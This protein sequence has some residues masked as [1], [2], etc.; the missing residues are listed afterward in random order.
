MSSREPL[1]FELESEMRRDG[2]LSCERNGEYQ[3]IRIHNRQSLIA[4]LSESFSST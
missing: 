1:S 3:H 2:D 4:D